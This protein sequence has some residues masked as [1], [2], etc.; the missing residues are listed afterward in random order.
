MNT[1]EQIEASELSLTP[2]A[3]INDGW[4]L[5]TGVKP[6]GSYNALT[7]SWGALGTLWGR[8]VALCFIRSTRYTKEFLD[9]GDRVTLSLF[10]P[11]EHRDELMVMGRTSGRDCDKVAKAGLEVAFE[12]ELPYFGAA[13]A[14]M[15]GTKLFAQELD[16]SCFTQKAEELGLY[17]ANYVKNTD[18]MH[19][20]YVFAIDKVFV[21]T[22]PQ[23]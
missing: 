1:F 22:E 5:V 10:E 6:D 11:G 16:G 4:M 3:A 2:F 12:D 19:T 13:G 23:E 15:L 14:V 20:M 8:P 9:A 21:A 18:G 7:A 17:E